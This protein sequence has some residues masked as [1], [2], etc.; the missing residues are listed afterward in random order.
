MSPPRVTIDRATTGADAEAVAALFRE[1]AASLGIDLGFQHF[2][3]EVAALPGA[4][5]GPRG[6]LLLARIGG[7]PAGCV[8]VRPLESG[9]CEMKRLYL[10]PAFR[11]RGLGEALARAAIDAA[12]ERGYQRMRLD[13]LPS[14][15][16]ARRLYEALGF[17]A[18]APYRFNP[19]EGAS[20]L[21][22][23][24]RESPEPP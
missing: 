12:R 3:A 14:M 4:Y 24:L 13:T 5:A 10:R 18:I 23:D 15:A 9:A 20:F 17:R 6:A 21:E 11:G 8:A 7:E 2:E 19:V 16:S 1:Y 22:L